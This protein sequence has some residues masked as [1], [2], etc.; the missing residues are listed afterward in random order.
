MIYDPTNKSLQELEREI[1]KAIEK[2]KALAI[3]S[4]EKNSLYANLEDLKKTVLAQ[5][6]PKEGSQASKEEVALRD[7]EYKKH[8]E[9]L[10]IARKDYLIAKAHHGSMEKIFE[11]L[12]S[13]LSSRREQLKKGYE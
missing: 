7:E 9:A 11:A 10:N 12:R 13:V 8:L 3:E 5:C 4:A 2:E 1:F 6:M